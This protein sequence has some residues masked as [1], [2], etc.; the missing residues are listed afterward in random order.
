MVLAEPWG[1]ATGRRGRI[2]RRLCSGRACGR[3]DG[4]ELTV[5]EDRRPRCGG[6]PVHRRLQ[7]P[8]WKAVAAERRGRLAAAAGRAEQRPG[9]RGPTAAGDRAEGPA[10]PP[11]KPR[12]TRRHADGRFADT[13]RHACP[14]GW[15]TPADKAERPAGRVLRPDRCCCACG[16]LL[17]DCVSPGP[18][19]CPRVSARGGGRCGTVHSRTVLLNP[20]PA[21][22]ILS[23]GRPPRR[24]G[25]CIR[26]RII[27]R[28]R[29]YFSLIFWR[30]IFFHPLG[31]TGLALGFAG[32]L[33]CTEAH[34]SKQ[35]RRAA[36]RV[37]VQFP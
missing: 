29:T 10:A 36:V 2:P 21:G 26:R 23:I 15:R 1:D 3:L 18:S 24:P 16:P 17:C 8:G 35:L 14:L 12:T 4:R 13:K 6:G 27:T 34:S 32:V 28:T 19:V 31:C 9:G 30:S 11:P 20:L 37:L 5:L 25:L 7:T 33:H 22:E